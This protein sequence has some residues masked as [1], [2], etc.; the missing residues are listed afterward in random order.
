MNSHAAL[1]AELGRIVGRAHLL[2][3]D[4]ATLRY[5]RGFRADAGACIAVVRPGSLVELWRTLEACIQN[6]VAILMQAANTG[7]TGGS[8]P[9]RA[10][11]R[12]TV[13]INAM[14]LDRL[15]LL[16]R[17]NQVI[18]L[19]GVTLHRLEQ[20]L[21]PLGREPH[22]VIGSSCFGASVVGGICN[23]SGGALVR[24]GPAYTELSIYAQVDASGALK[25]VNELGVDLG[26]DPETMLDRLE[27]GAFASTASRLPA[28]DPDYASHVRMIDAATPARF[29]ADPR[30][31]HAASGSAGKIAVLGVRL[32]T[33]EKPLEPVS[34]YVGTNRPADLTLL[35]RA[36]LSSAGPLPISAEYLHR[37][38]FDIAYEYGRDTFFMIQRFGTHRLPTFFAIKARVDALAARFGF[39]DL[40][41]R[42]LQALSRFLPDHLPM[43]LHEWR[44]RYAHHLILKVDPQDLSWTKAILEQAIGQDGAWFECSAD[45]ARKAA[46]HRFVAAGAAVR[47]AISERKQIGG[48]VALD[49]ALPRNAQSWFGDVPDDLRDSVRV[50]M[51]YGHFLC[52][53]FHRDYLLVPGADPAAV[54]AR[55]LE[56]LD[57]EG[58]E[59]PAEHNVGRH[60][61]A[62]PVLAGFYR[63]LDPTNRF[64]PGIGQTSAEPDW[65]T[66]DAGA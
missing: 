27:R 36:L 47:M 35:R 53:V 9:D 2:T 46:L 7:L 44:R 40:A 39:A 11:N 50:V 38:T 49:I 48:I 13:I 37:D 61:V 14:R 64:N 63:S 32:D 56:C 34:L 4:R 26:N 31:L 58:A 6:N 43:V 55:L 10:S 3:S 59:Y 15:H 51:R 18:C 1:I 54:K 5:R 65:A 24:R 42:L 45:E 62:K 33:F 60:Y 22:S 20:A 23:N 66:I 12:P 30:R 16:D 19:P 17:G 57:Q 28:S 29:N 41:D 8:T 52:H 25:L 21:A